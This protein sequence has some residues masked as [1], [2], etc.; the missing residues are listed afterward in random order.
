MSHPRTTHATG[1]PWEPIVGDSRAVRVGAMVFVS[2]TSA[3]T[4]VSDS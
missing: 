1:T 2:G 4:V 3:T